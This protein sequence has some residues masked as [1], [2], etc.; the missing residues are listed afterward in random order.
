MKKIIA[1][2]LFI[3]VI[4]LT[5]CAIVD[6]PIVDISKG[7]S[8]DT[9]VE[10]FEESSESISESSNDISDIVSEPEDIF[11]PYVT[12]ISRA[13]FPIYKGPGYET[14]FASYVKKSSAYTIVEEKEDEF[15]ILWGRLKSGAGWID[16]ERLEIEETRGPVISIM[17]L[18]DQVLN[19]G[20]YLYCPASSEEFPAQILLKA[21]VSLAK[22]EF[23]PGY[24][25]EES[26]VVA[27]DTVY[28]KKN[29]ASGAFLLVDIYLPGDMSVYGIRATDVDGY[30]YHYRV[31]GNMSGEGEDYLMDSYAP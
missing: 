28:T 19:S 8:S 26:D 12:K 9:S 31:L 11:E 2:S 21:N 23:Y 14:G 4:V 20:D 6:D 13:D 10:S 18:T 24:I 29:C 25:G 5:S 22:I 3:F 27:E 30:T 17:T 1:L 15:G 16:L 7:E